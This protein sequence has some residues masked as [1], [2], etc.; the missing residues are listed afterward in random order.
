MFGPPPARGRPHLLPRVLDGAGN[1]HDGAWRAAMAAYEPVGTCPRGGD[2][3]LRPGEPYKLGP[4]W[5]YP[6]EC[7]RQ[8]CDYETAAHGARP[9]AKGRG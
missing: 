6:A 4:V 1:V 9:A 5:W 8:D 2:H 3:L 7:R